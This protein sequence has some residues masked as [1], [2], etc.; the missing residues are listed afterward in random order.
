MKMQPAADAATDTSWDAYRKSWRG[1]L[2]EIA[3]IPGELAAVF[4]IFSMSPE[5][6]GVAALGALE[7]ALCWK[8]DDVEYDKYVTTQSAALKPG[9]T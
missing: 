8:L 6:L 5:G 1:T 2:M 3:R 4:G 7:V 9:P